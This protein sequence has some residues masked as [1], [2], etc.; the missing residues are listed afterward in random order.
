MARKPKEKEFDFDKAYKDFMEK[1]ENA[2]IS[3]DML[4]QTMMK[5]FKRLKQL[6]DE[7]YAGIE[8]MGVSYVEAGSKGQP[9]FKAN[10]LN[11][12]YLNANKALVLTCEKIG[13][14]LEKVPMTTEDNDW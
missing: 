7:F 9:T 14:Y 5:E 8:K 1:A 2:G 13:D 11:K 3:N 12:D 4:F 6:S 10:P